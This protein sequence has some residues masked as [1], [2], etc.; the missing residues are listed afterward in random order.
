[1]SLMHLLLT[2]VFY[3]ERLNNPA[4]PCENLGIEDI[5]SLPWVKEGAA[6]GPPP[7]AL[8][9]G[10]LRPGP[11]ESAAGEALVGCTPHPRRWGIVVVGSPRGF[12]RLEQ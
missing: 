6:A 4:F 7:V 2:W 9:Q 1:M 5:S 10:W 11:G 3:S 12:R 8:G